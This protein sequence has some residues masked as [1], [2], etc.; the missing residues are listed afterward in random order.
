MHF[1]PCKRNSLAFLIMALC[2]IEVR[3]GRV[4]DVGEEDVGEEV[5]TKSMGVIF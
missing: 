3:M 5:H 2:L 4:A 1:Q